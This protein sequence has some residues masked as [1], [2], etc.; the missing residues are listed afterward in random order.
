[1][2]NEFENGSI[3]ATRVKKFEISFFCHFFGLLGSE[4]R[5]EFA[6]YALAKTTKNKIKTISQMVE[7]RH[8]P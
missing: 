2:R 3:Y 7:L 1:M 5:V 4:I 6:Y 8:G